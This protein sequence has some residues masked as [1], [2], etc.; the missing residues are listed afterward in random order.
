VSTKPIN[1]YKKQ[2]TIFLFFYQLEKILKTQV[3][4]KFKNICTG[5]LSMNLPTTVMIKLYHYF[6]N[7]FS[8]F[9]YQ[10][11]DEIYLNTIMFV[12]HLFKFK[13]PDGTLF[14]NYISSILPLIQK[15]TQFLTFLKRVLYTLQRVFKFIGVKIALSGKL[16]GFTRAQSKHIQV[17]CVSLQSIDMPYISGYSHAFTAA[18]KI[19]VKI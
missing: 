2:L 11:K 8:Q 15:H 10:F 6:L 4:F 5:F 16:N 7:K 19:G 13:R 12:L 17:G 1:K 9:K 3:L 14:A 18:G